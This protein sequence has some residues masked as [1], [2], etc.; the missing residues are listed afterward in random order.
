MLGL[1]RVLLS[2]GFPGVTRA[3]EI[4]HILPGTASGLLLHG[5]ILPS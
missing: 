4:H 5:S 1:V 2:G 3:P